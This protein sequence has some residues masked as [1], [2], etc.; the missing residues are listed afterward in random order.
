M[1]TNLQKNIYLF[2][3]IYFINSFLFAE[4]GCI[5]FLL[6]LFKVS[7]SQRRATFKV[8]KIQTTAENGQTYENTIKMK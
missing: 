1:F 8:L 7:F 3:F 6:T 2:I 4:K 5:R